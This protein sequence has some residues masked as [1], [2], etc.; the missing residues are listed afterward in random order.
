M[1][2]TR[3]Y[4]IKNLETGKFL[5]GI[6][7]KKVKRNIQFS[8]DYTD[9][10]SYMDINHVNSHVECLIRCKLFEDLDKCE[11]VSYDVVVSEVK[12]SIRMKNLRARC[13]QIA[14]MDSLRGII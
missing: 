7:T 2:K 8:V 13:E 5:N 14:L 6:S 1:Q 9:D 4:R 3:A 12:G 10:S 11:V